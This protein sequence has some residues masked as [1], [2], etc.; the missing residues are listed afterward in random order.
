MSLVRIAARMACVEALKHRTLVGDRVLDSQIGALFVTADGLDTDEKR[1]FIA[2][3]CEGSRMTGDSIRG[4]V[5]NGETEFL[6]ES[7][8][9][10]SHLERDA[11]TDQAVVLEGIPATDDAFEFHLDIVMRQVG[12][13]LT[14]PDNQWAEIFRSLSTVWSV[15]ERVRTAGDVRGTRLA[16]HQLKIVASLIAD[17]VKG[18][19]LKPEHP[20]E[21][22]F[23]KAL[24]TEDPKLCAQVEVMQAQ[25]VGDQAAMQLALRRYGATALEAAALLIGV[26]TEPASSDGLTIT[27]GG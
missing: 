8:I 11:E 13:A 27:T 1:P 7:G 26:G 23:A 15:S 6:I 25:I 14:D 12:D 9:L 17:P 22:F 16:A 5:V 18:T 2:V 20:V 10:M 24:A 4:L 19:S 21:R 3:Y